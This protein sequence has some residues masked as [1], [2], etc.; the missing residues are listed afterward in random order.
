MNRWTARIAAISAAAL[1]AIGAVGFMAQAEDTKSLKGQA[2][3]EVALTTLDGSEF[4]LSSLK[5][6]VVLLDYWATWCPPCV[7]GLPHVAEMAA[8]KALAEK[9]LKVYA[10]N[11]K[12][13]EDKV[14]AFLAE[15]KLNLVVPMDPKGEFGKSYKVRGIPTTVVVG[16]DGN[17][18]E[19]FVG[20]GPG[21][22]KKILAAVESALKAGQ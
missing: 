2:A 7:K 20:F 18:A 8:D 4:K 21:S 9:G 19:V 1:L 5:G 17:I 16:R 10:I 14:K 11:S 6:S 13:T 22:E 15:H 12:E 3:P